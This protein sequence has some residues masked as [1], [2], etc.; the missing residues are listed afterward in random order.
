M[1][2]RKV[3]LYIVNIR[4]LKEQRRR[5]LRKRHLKSEFAPLQTLL[6]L[7]HLVYFVKCWQT[8]FEL[9]SKGLYQILR[10]VKETMRCCF[11]FPFS[12][13]REIRHFHVVV[14]VQRRLRN[15]QKK[16]DVR[17][18]LLFCLLNVLVFWSSR[19]HCR[20]GILNSP[21]PQQN[22]D[23]LTL[24]CFIFFFFT[25]RRNILLKRSLKTVF[26]IFILRNSAR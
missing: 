25:I 20:R 19:C 12:T 22:L 7:F 2:A 13:K 26:S 15:V 18:K 11:V 14:A 4:E 1:S 3:S 17:V 16:G 10:K 23:C 8:F 24:L 21:L 9:N 5:R 6:R